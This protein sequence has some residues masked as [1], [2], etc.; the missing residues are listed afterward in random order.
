MYSDPEPV[1][2]RRTS[3]RIGEEERRIAIVTGVGIRGVPELFTVT[4]LAIIQ[5]YLLY[6]LA[7]WMIGLIR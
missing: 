1:R 2:R 7:L 3:R 5:I 6:R 4:T